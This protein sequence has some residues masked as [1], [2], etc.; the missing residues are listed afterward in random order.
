MLL[1][2][3][4]LQLGVDTASFT[5]PAATP[6]NRG[7]L[8]PIKITKPHSLDQIGQF[9]FGDRYCVVLLSGVRVDVR[10]LDT[11][12]GVIKSEFLL[13]ET[14]DLTLHLAGKK[15]QTLI[16]RPKAEL[17]RPWGRNI[18]QT[19]KN[20]QDWVTIFNLSGEWPAE[21]I[22][23]PRPPQRGNQTWTS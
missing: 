18:A 20:I 14:Y 17:G 19:C 9:E 8:P 1:R 4:L 2:D 16:L 6:V 10:Q 23:M 3:L 15:S 11:L 5:A 7:Q 22:A 12:L 21:L 13:A